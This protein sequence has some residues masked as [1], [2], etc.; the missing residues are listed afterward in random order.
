MPVLALPPARVPRALRAGMIVLALAGG[1]A[2]RPVGPA[3][4]PS[5]PP[6]AP[7]PASSSPPTGPPPTAVAPD[8]GPRE[9][10][11]LAV[12]PTLP[13]LD[14]PLATARGVLAGA[15]R[16]WRALGA[17]AGPLRLL[18]GTP[19]D[20]GTASTSAAAA[21]LRAVGRDRRAVAAVPASAVGPTVRVLSV[22][23]IHP[24]RRPAAYPLTIPGVAPAPVTTAAIT[25]DVMLGRRVGQA[26]ARS[27]D[28]AAPLRPLARRLAAADVT[29][30]NLESTLSRAGAPRQ[31]GDSFAA[32]ARALAGLRLAGFDVLSLANNHTGDFGPRALVETVDR[33]RGAG[34]APVGAGADAAAAA[35]P[36]VVR[37]GGVRF[38][39][40][41]FNAIGETPRAGSG[42]PGAVSLRMPPR[43]GPLAPGDLAAQVRAVRQL[44]PRVDVLVVLPHWG[45]Q[46]TYRPVSAQRTVARALVDAG[47]DLVVG[48]HPHWVQGVEIHRGSL[49]VHSL[50]NFVFDMDFSRQTREGVVLELIF[51]GA[52]LKA[53]EFVPVLIGPDFAPRPLAGAAGR[54]VLDAI[55]AHSGPPFTQ[56]G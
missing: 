43:T 17:P 15:V 28:N 25:G 3:A 49:V 36:A 33:V 50:G 14:V 37:R 38:G 22:A 34:I 21:A 8:P 31:G 35:V 51:W 24:L 18:V 12:H 32:D 2:C 23:G 45:Q 41:A 20:R 11:V 7:P 53:A 47:A 6:T 39:F 27:G 55:W 42:T 40:L 5:P 30:G 19:P 29:V 9:P 48:G 56:A 16:D 46:Y 1:A 44:R 54:R 26:L 13:A 52:R 10:L 4:T